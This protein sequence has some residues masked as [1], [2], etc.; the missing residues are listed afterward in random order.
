MYTCLF[1][2]LAL[3][4][5]G[6]TAPELPE[7]VQEAEPSVRQAFERDFVWVQDG[8]LI[9]VNQYGG[10]VGASTFV[11]PKR[12]IYGEEMNWLEFY[13][14]TGNEDIAKKVRA[15]RR[16][17]MGMAIGGGAGFLIGTGM[18]F[19]SLGGEYSWV[20]DV[21]N[22]SLAGTAEEAA[23]REALAN[24]NS[25]AIRTTGYVLM[26]TGALVGGL[27]F[28]VRTNPLEDSGVRRVAAEYNAR[29]LS[30]LGLTVEGSGAWVPRPRPLVASIGANLQPGGAGVQLTLT[31]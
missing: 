27:A 14:H 3:A 15:R 13:T 12:G 26:G 23:C 5:I 21:E 22:C 6:H 16:T 31:H 20:G 10:V 9:G 24:D 19:G 28:I 18:I 2:L 17:R 11:R 25:A 7:V 30:D 8:I 1:A 29:L 4:G